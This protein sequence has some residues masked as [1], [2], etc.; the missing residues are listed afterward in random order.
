MTTTPLQ[1]RK[2]T[3]C[4]AVF[5]LTPEYWYRSRHTSWGYRSD[6]KV[7]SRKRDAGRRNT[8]YTED[9]YWNKLVRS[10]AMTLLSKMFPEEYKQCQI[11][12]AQDFK[13]EEKVRRQQEAVARLNQSLGAL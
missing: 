12:A 3:K 10:R 9:Q 4:G 13:R 2:C 1:S 11:Q 6:C 5:P 8:H 7:C